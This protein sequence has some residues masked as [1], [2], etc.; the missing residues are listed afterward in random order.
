[1][2]G[3]TTW[4][5]PLSY[6]YGIKKLLHSLST[7]VFHF[8]RNVPINIQSERC[9]GMT[10]IRLHG[11]CIVA[12]HQGVNSK[13]MPQIME[14]Y[15]FYACSITDGHEMLDDCSSDE[16]LSQHVCEY[17]VFGIMPALTIDLLISEFSYILCAQR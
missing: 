15:I 7:V 2:P 12:N 1:L 6:P 10:E 5:Y 13:A 14:A 4:S 17:V 8:L 16:M 9:R 3:C 11:L